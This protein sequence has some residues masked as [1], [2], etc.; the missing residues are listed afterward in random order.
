MEQTLEH[1]QAEIS[2]WLLKKRRKKL[3]GWAKRWFELSKAG[4][5]SYSASPTSVTRGSIQILLATITLNPQQRIIHIDSGS[6]LF[7]L[8]CQ[9]DDEYKK[10]TQALKAYRNDELL[11]KEYTDTPQE[12]QTQQQ[13]DLILPPEI[14][15]LPNSSSTSSFAADYHSADMIWSQIDAGI[16]NAELLSS[17]IAILKKNTESLFHRENLSES[18]TLAKESDLITSLATEQ[19]RQ[20]REIQATI[21]HLLKG[22]PTLNSLSMTRSQSKIKLPT[23]ADIKPTDNDVTLLRTRS[24]NTSCSS[25]HNS[26]MSD[27]FFDAESVVL[28]DDDED[29][30]DQQSIVST[31]DSSTVSTSDEDDFEEEEEDLGKSCGII[32]K[33]RDTH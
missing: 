27:Q 32:T 24:T 20:W 33:A 12:E 26:F 21:Q 3:Q 14:Q 1:P 30:A 25:I 9:T 4:V 7:H 13:Q 28:T 22:D 17:N 29:Y 16:R 19:A 31:G 15:L 8:R 23:E 2:G 5:L 18:F 6:T 10:W 11:H